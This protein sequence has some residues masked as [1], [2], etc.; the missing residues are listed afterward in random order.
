[1]RGLARAKGKPLKTRGRQEIQGTLVNVSLL[2]DV[3][4]RQFQDEVRRES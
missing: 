3:E 2:D 4:S 1:M